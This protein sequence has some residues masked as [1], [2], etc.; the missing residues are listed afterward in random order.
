M[1]LGYHT[2]EVRRP[3]HDAA[4]CRFRRYHRSCQQTE[5]VL[6][7]GVNLYRYVGTFPSPMGDIIGLENC[8]S[9]E[10]TLW[11]IGDLRARQL[12]TITPAAGR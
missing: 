12:R 11:P 2:D 7:D 10:V 8:R 9:L 3:E 4:S 6:T 1:S 5:P